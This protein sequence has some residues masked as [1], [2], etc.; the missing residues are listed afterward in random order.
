MDRFR[1]REK[2]DQVRIYLQRKDF[3]NTSTIDT[4]VTEINNNMIQ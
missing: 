4:I 2:T 3:T 1:F